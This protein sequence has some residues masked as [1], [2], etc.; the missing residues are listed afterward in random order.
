MKKTI[1][2]FTLLLILLSINL[3]LTQYTSFGM[4]LDSFQE[5]CLSDYYKAQTVIVYELNS[6]HPEMV[7]EVK[8]PDGKILFHFINAT[9]LFSV[10]T[11]SNGFYQVCAKN[12]GKFKGEITLTIKT[13]VSANDY[14]SVAKSKDLEPIDYELDRIL[15]RQYMLNHLNRVS[16][17]KQNQFGSIYKSISNRIIFYSLFMIAGMIFIGIVETL[18]LKRFMEKRKII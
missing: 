9:S 8:S 5:R 10:T 7:L 12:I 4:E 11:N 17:E 14:S 2:I 3:T 6:N 15:K 13:G 1:S 18:Y 16:Q